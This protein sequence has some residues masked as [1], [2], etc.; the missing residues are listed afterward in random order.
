MKEDLWSVTDI[1]DYAMKKY[2]LPKSYNNTGSGTTLTDNYKKTIRRLLAKEPYSFY[3]TRASA[4]ITENEKG[5]NSKDE[6]RVPELVA[7]YI[8]E[9]ELRNYFI[10]LE[11][12]ALIEN[13][14]KKDDIAFNL[15]L[16]KLED[17]NTAAKDSAE[18]EGSNEQL[19]K[20]A[21][22]I[23]DDYELDQ[24]IDQ[25]ID[26]FMLRTLFSLYFDFNEDAYR[27]DYR[28]ML[29]LMNIEADDFV[30]KGYSM[31]SHKLD[32]PLEY[33]CRKKK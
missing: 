24:Y 31:L 8:V 25:L 4:D 13:K 3:I 7:K 23:I 26:R 22:D 10:K 11:D 1:V 17:G 20:L 9:I 33:Y 2:Y 15:W 5:N 32:N 19:E 18:R 28:H 30:K 14:Y 6:Y 16:K 21:N 27:K 29:N 12:K